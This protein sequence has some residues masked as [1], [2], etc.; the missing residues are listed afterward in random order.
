MAKKKASK[1]TNSSKSK[2]S[3][4]STKTNIESTSG[5]SDCQLRSHRRLTDSLTDSNAQFHKGLDHNV[6]GE[7]DGAQFSKMVASL[8]ALN[9][10]PRNHAKS[11]FTLRDAKPGPGE[12]R[13][14]VNPQSGWALDS[15]LSDPC[16]F[17]IPPAP[18]LHSAEAASEAIED[19]WMALLRDVPFIQWDTNNDVSAAASE[20]SEYPLFV[21]A[22]NPNGNPNESDAAFQSIG[23]NHKSV[24]RGGELARYSNSSAGISE[25]VGP[26]ISQFLFHEIPYGTLTIPQRFIHASPGVDYLTDWSDWLGVQNGENRDARQNLIGTQQLDQRRYMTTMRDLATYVHFDQLYEAYLNAALILLNNDYPT[27]PGN[28]YGPGCSAIGIGNDQSEQYTETYN[29]V[30][31]IADVEGHCARRYPD[32]DGFGSFGGPSVLSLVTEVAT[33]AL[34]AVWRQKWTLLRLRPEAYGGLVERALGSGHTPYNGFCPS[35]LSMLQH[36]EA[37]DRTRMGLDGSCRWN[38][39][40]SALLTMAFP[41]GSPTH[42]AYG[43]GHA[44]VAGACVTILKAFFDGRVRFSN[45]VQANEDGSQLLHY[46]ETDASQMTV[47]SELHKLAANIA[48]GRDMA[49]V[50]WRSDYTQSMLLGQRVAIDM[51]Y[52]QKDTYT[53]NWSYKFESFGGKPI[54]LDANGIDYDSGAKCFHDVPTGC[55][56]AEFLKAII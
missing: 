38:S 3:R 49:G 8:K 5:Y 53:E 54:V 45:P 9:A 25:D 36:S 48:I 47:Q 56:L 42:P 26:F 37:I 50:H 6:D 39:T 11:G 7:V 51:L 24:F 15:E 12:Y 14:F 21:N 31:D 28:P 29:K 18:A 52:R 34:K 22:Q 32:Q 40:N 44:T 16:C 4:K 35:V 33:R 17:E 20:L 19:Y 43:A 46:C 13:N 41:E 23:L 10:D 2:S 1:R 30:C 55:N 27:N